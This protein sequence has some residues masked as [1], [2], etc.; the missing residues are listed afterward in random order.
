MM[1]YDHANDKKEKGADIGFLL[2]RAQPPAK[3]PLLRTPHH[4]C[5]L[6]H[7]TISNYHTK[8]SISNYQQRSATISYY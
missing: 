8:L 6:P 1:L 2:P 3:N 4:I 7:H 5:I